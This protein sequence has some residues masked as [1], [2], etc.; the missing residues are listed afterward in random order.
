MNICSKCNKEKPLEQFQGKSKQYKHCEDC[1]NV[2][3]QWR[4]KN[5]ETVSLYN[6]TYRNNNNEQQE[7]IYIYARRFGTDNEW[8]QF[9]SQLSASKQLNVY[10]ANVNKVLNGSLTTT[11]GYEF[12]SEKVIV[13]NEK[14][15]WDIVKKDNNIED[16]CKGK[17]SIKRKPHKIVED[18][19]GKDCS[20]CKLWKP[21]DNY[22]NSEGHWD[23]LR[24]ECKDC[25]VT[26]RKE[27]RDKIQATNTAYESRRKAIDPEFKLL[28][29][30]RSRLGSAIKSQSVYKDKA[31]LEL[32]GCSISHLKGFL[33]AKF[34]DG[35]TWKNHGEWHID[36]IKPC[37][38]FNLLDDQQKKQCFHYTNLQPLWAKENLSK[39]AK[40]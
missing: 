38:S 12:K 16:Q 13:N 29:T 4:E 28:K 14:I 3:R 23:K 37:S 9:D 36:H 24:V 32:V 15:D 11:G 26:W 1:R 19:V 20:K 18:V 40:I 34:K 17:P 2:S 22:N 27:N 5:K 39:G 8:Q 21:L 30:L 31:T 25:I 7:K 33:E 35:M 6:K 10:A